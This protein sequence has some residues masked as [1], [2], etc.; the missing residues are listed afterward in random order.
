MSKNK[1]NYSDNN[2]SKTR[3]PIGID[4][5]KT[6]TVNSMSINPEELTE[7]I[8]A[9]IVS[10]DRSDRVVRPTRSKIKL[11]SYI[12]KEN[13]QTILH[14]TKKDRSYFSMLEYIRKN[15]KLAIALN[16]D[17]DLLRDFFPLA[18][19]R[20]V[21]DYTS[22]IIPKV[23]KR[24]LEE[25]NSKLTPRK[26]RGFVLA[27]FKSI[28]RKNG[29]KITNELLEEINKRFNYQRCIKLFEISKAETT[30]INWNLLAKKP[31]RE[32]NDLKTFYLNFINNI[33]RLKT[34]E[35]IKK[36]LGYQKVISLTQKFITKFT[37]DKDHKKKLLELIKHQDKD[38][39]SRLIIWSIAKYFAQKELDENFRSAEEIPGWLTLFLIEGTNADDNIERIPIRS[40]KFCFWA[41]FNLRNKLKEYQLYPED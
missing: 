34:D 20:E 1:I 40:L 26:R 7:E 31:T 24:V 8:Q 38:F 19:V 37:T 22:R 18:L 16:E 17:F 10:F 5:S 25:E 28:C 2:F 39:I 30:L 6:K 9:E 21:E 35:I 23:E 36:N 33:N 12:S 15:E 41:E 32:L 14:K 29:R 3:L 27:I 13:L 11:G 4:F